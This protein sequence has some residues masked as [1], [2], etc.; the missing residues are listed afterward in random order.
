MHES[1]G[2]SRI[3]SHHLQSPTTWHGRD[4]QC[5]TDAAL[6]QPRQ[7]EL[8]GGS[9][10]Y[11][12]CSPAARIGRSEVDSTVSAPVT[13]MTNQFVAQ[14]AR[15]DARHRRV[16][17]RIER[18]YDTPIMNNTHRGVY[19][20]LLVLDTLGEGWRA[21]GDPWLSWDIEHADGTKVEV[22]QSAACQGWHDGTQRSLAA[23]RK[24]ARFGIA[25]GSRAWTQEAGWIEPADRLA[26][27]YVFAWHPE[28]DIGLANH[29]HH[30]EWR[31]YVVRS[32]ALPDG[33]KSIGL[34][35]VERLA[36]SVDIDGL[37][38]AVQSLML[39]LG[40]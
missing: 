24:K 20:Q 19:V 34:S 18:Q 7:Q 1:N 28:V 25:K 9:N 11:H 5:E 4:L 12:E 32:D 15:H 10:R 27:I 33:Q 30:A 21:H 35:G 2:P 3:A 38:A 16:L 14:R 17:R 29:R 6:P 39:D 13:T 22:K 23:A 31:F 26:D 37:A 40:Q 36:D 8:R